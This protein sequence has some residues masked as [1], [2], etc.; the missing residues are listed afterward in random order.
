MAGRAPPL[1]A[2]SEGMRASSQALKRFLFENLYRHPRVMASMEQARGIV[3]ELF[4]AYVAAPGEMQAGHAARARAC[5]GDNG[6]LRR[7]VA[8]YIAGMTD[9]Y[10]A[11]EHERLTGRRAW[12]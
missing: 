2:F 8:D 11:R 1:V 7:V 3:Q 10:A 6:R 9:R 4:A 12:S 5:A